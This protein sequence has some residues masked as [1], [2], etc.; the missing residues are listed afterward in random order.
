MVA[1]VRG[2]RMGDGGGIEVEGGKGEGSLGSRGLRGRV[3]GRW[4]RRRT[5]RISRSLASIGVKVRGMDGLGLSSK[6]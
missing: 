3:E 1:S 4:R 6:E 2:G 5:Q